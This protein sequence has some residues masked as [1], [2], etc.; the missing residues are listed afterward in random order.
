[1]QTTG[2]IITVCFTY[3]DLHILLILVINAKDTCIGLPIPNHPPWVMITL[4]PVYTLHRDRHR[5]VI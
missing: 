2:L 3:K 5:D 4:F 1:M